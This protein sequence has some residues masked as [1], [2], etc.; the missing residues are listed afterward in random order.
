MQYPGSQV[1][2][3]HHEVADPWFPTVFGAPKATLR[4]HDSLG[5]TEIR[6]ALVLTVQ[7]YKLKSA[8]ER[9]KVTNK[10]RAG[11]KR[12][13]GGRFLLCTTSGIL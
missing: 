11:P 5:L 6:K 8:K 3:L 2:P 10:Q 13:P 9:T 12:I 4:F 1:F 7:G